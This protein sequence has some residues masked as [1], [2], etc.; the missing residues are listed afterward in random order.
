[1]KIAGVPGACLAC[2]SDAVMDLLFC[3]RCVI[4]LAFN[5]LGG[6]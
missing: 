5:D 1:M 4:R 6:T 2:I 3:R